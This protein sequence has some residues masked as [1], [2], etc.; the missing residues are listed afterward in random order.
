MPAWKHGT[1]IAALLLTLDDAKKLH[2][3]YK[4]L[5]WFIY[6][7]TKINTMVLY[8]NKCLSPFFIIRSKDKWLHNEETKRQQLSKVQHKKPHFLG[9]LSIFTLLQHVNLWFCITLWAVRARLFTTARQWT[10][11]QSWGQLA[12]N[13]T[14]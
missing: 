5:V 9:L 8:L 7:T 1:H 12:T 6:Q 2:V 11:T 10:N 4:T 14:F 3:Y 13:L